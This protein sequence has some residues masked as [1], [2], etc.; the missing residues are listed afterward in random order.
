[1]NEESTYRLLVVANRTCPCPGLLNHLFERVHQRR[2][3]HQVLVIAPAL[4][5]R[6]HH[7]VSDVDGAI[8][9]AD[10][11]LKVAL[12]YLERLGVHAD[13]EIGD[14][15]PL[16]AIE[17]ALRSFAADEIVISTYPPGRS[18]WLERNLP[19]R[20]QRFDVPIVHFVS[21]HGID[22]AQPGAP[23]AA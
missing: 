3:P 7:M 4:N 18:N 22:S 1:V 6:L 15:D 20:A 19:K 17:D 8:A 9:A 16:L 10:A 21:E 12:E 2:G 5:S 14:S 11:R 23:I 13:G